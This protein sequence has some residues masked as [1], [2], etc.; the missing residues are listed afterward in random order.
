M[1]SWR[2]TFVLVG[3][4]GVLFAL[5]ASTIREPIRRNLLASADGK[6]T[7]LSFG[8]GMAQ[9]RMRWQSVTGISL[10]MV[11]QGMI[12]YGLLAWVPTFF[13]RVHHWS[14][15]QSGRA[16]A[17][18]L[19][20]FGC[21]GMYVGGRLSDWWQKRGV[22]EGPLK[23]AV[24][25][26][27]GTLLLMPVAMLVPG[28]E[29][30]VALLAPALFFDALAM[31]T[32]AAAL[33]HI[34]PNQVR[35]QVSA[36]YLFLLNLGGGSLGP[37]LPGVFNDYLFHDPNKVGY[38]LAI[39]IAIGAIGMLIASLLTFGS[40]RTHYEM[41]QARLQPPAWSDRRTSATIASQMVGSIKW[42]GLL[43]LAA[44]ATASSPRIAQENQCSPRQHP[45][46]GS[47]RGGSQQGQ[48]VTDLNQDDF[49]VFDNGKPQK[50]AAFNIISS[51]TTPGKSVPLPP[52]A[53]SNRLITEGQEPAGITIVLYDMLNTAPED[54]CLGAQALVHYV[55]TLQ[56]GDHFALYSLE[57]TLSVI[58]DFT[59]DPE[60][61]RRAARRASPEASTDQ[62]ADDLA[63]DLLAS[64]PDTG[65]DIA[66]AMQ[67]N[68]IMNMQD[69]AQINRAV[70]TT[71]AME[72]IAKHLQGIPGRKKLIWISSSFA[73]Q[74]TDMRSHN[75][76]TNHRAQGLRPAKST[77]PCAR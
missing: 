13:Q 61:I 8:E 4:P 75:G 38:S 50:V 64:A 55:D 26:A 71:K 12:T 56:S 57:K 58:Q 63:A 48:A 72:L 17:A 23:V 18:I 70:I 33:Q 14:P 5:L 74:T 25:S 19:L 65:D 15:G 7:R 67:Q 3:L 11:C 45:A 22:A 40:Y 29:W 62:T 39:T 77:R 41:M 49:T 31:G 1:A 59:D 21:G 76:T 36:L 37:L 68:S 35:G 16:L 32:A 30:S 43:C 69:M 46:G 24:I 2:L 10:A 73:A 52:G 42:T 34:F 60:R 51:R 47:G 20:T 28:P 66:N 44:A 6:A 54:Q 53:V 27:I 9:I